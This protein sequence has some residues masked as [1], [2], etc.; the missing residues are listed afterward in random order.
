MILENPKAE[1]LLFDL[2]N[3]KYTE[4]VLTYIQEQFPTTKITALFGNS[5]ET[6]S[7]YIANN[8]AEVNTYDV[9]HLDGGHTE[10][11]F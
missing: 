5:V 10:D 1:Y 7:T 2:N 3:H 6:M 9:C 8:L 11:I 4:P